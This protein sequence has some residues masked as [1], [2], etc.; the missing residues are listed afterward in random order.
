M[1][2]KLADL[3]LVAVAAAK[4]LR[5]LNPEDVVS[6]ERLADA[7]GDRTLDTTVD[8]LNHYCE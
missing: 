6:L 2:T 3:V 7:L 5:R 1:G 4:E 8:S